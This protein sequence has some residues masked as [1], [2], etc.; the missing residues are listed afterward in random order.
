MK[1][2]TL[3]RSPGLSVVPCVHYNSYS[4]LLNWP[5]VS[6]FYLYYLVML[7]HDHTLCFIGSPCCSVS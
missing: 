7:V 3:V 6:L 1:N 2:N 4:T 5:I